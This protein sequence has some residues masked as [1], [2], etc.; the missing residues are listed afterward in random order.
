MEPLF[1]NDV[2]LQLPNMPLAIMC[3]T[4]MTKLSVLYAFVLFKGTA[5][6]VSLLSAGFGA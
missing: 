5:H 3:F 6:L 2:T 4:L 1:E